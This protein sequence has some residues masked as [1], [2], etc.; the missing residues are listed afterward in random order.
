MPPADSN[1]TAQKR[2]ILDYKAIASSPPENIIASP[3]KDDLFRWAA[4]IIGP[5]QTPWE[6][7]V[8][9]LELKFTSEYPTK[10]PAVKVLTKMFH[11]NIFNNGNICL[12]LLSTKWTPALGV[13]AILLSIQSLLTDP[14]PMSPAN[15]EAAALFVNDRHT[16]NLRVSMCTRNS[17]EDV[18]EEPYTELLRTIID[19]GEDD[20][21]GQEE[22]EEGELHEFQRSV[23]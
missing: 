13:S 6:G 1:A 20:E 18:K 3:Y 2:L 16:Y 23:K 19:E 22:E 8:I 9:R 12:D 11:P 7:A 10:P 5:S 14:N 17:W 21:Q 4:I 15:N